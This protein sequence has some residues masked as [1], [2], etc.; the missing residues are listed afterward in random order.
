[1]VPLLYTPAPPLLAV[2]PVIL[3]PFMVKVPWL[4]TPPPRSPLLPVIEPAQSVK[5]F[6][7]STATP[8]TPEAWVILPVESPLPQSVMVRLPYVL[9]CESCTTRMALPKYE[10]VTVLPLR[11]SVI[12]DETFHWLERFTS[13]V[14]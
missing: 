2:L 4:K 3:P 7:L 5:S 12:S 11:H 9:V 1:M 8:R 14:R 13:L 10:L 6:W